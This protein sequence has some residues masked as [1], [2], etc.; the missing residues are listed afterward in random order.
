[1]NLG[2]LFLCLLTQLAQFKAFSSDLNI[3]TKE[4]NRREEGKGQEI[5]SNLEGLFVYPEMPCLGSLLAKD[6]DIKVIF[7]QKKP[8]CLITMSICTY[9]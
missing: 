9:P 6:K 1:M 5:K 4:E 7:I 3:V 8:L 2:L